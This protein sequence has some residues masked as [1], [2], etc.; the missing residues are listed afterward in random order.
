MA[1][2]DTDLSVPIDWRDA[3]FAPMLAEL[4]GHILKHHGR[5]HSIHLLLRFDGTA[6]QTK[7]AL[8][9]I[10]ENVLSALAQL[11]QV[12]A[13]KSGGAQDGGTVIFLYLSASGYAKLGL[14]PPDDPAFRDGMRHRGDLADPDVSAW[15]PHHA[16]A[17]DALTIIADVNDT[18]AA[19]AET[20][21][22][23]ILDAGGIAIVG[24][25][26]GRAL[27]GPGG[28]GHEHFGY[29]DG[30]SQ[31]LMLADDVADEAAQMG[32]DRWN[33]AFGPGDIALVR[34]PHGVSPDSFGSYL[35]YRKLEQDVRGF[36]IAERALAT[37]A[38]IVDRER[39]GAMVVGR[40]ENGT[41][42]ALSGSDMPANATNNFNYAEPATGNDPDGLKCPFQAHIRKTN[43]RGDTG[44][45][46]SERQ[47]L[48]PRRGIP[49]GERSDVWT[50]DIDATKPDHGV[51]LIFMAFNQDIGRQ[52]EFTQ[53]LWANNP[54]F[55]F[56]RDPGLDP[57]IGQGDRDLQL[58]RERW[59]DATAPTWPFQFEQFVHMR[60]GE[61][62]FAPSI[63]FL[64]SLA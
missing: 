59:G 23:P 2:T 29:V 12:A 53:S 32:I 7:P 1:L 27:R 64:K 16:E 22:L 4:Q 40:F 63:G 14:T 6:E 20:G 58:W 33:P 13:R 3:R 37:A 50:N 61:Y 15:E 25:D 30:I 46:D 44:D 47:H 34:D 52:F 31:P 24:R 26:V 17:I 62:Y 8:A 55:V 28:K 43:P 21:F 19:A 45:G 54:G 51:G 49:F 36:K 39:A 42:V 41:P 5:D 11:R 18:E 48:M 56:G 60:G 9:R 38:H 57:V 35:V 10:G